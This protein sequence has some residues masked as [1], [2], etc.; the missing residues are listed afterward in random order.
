LAAGE[1]RP[2]NAKNLVD[3]GERSFHARLEVAVVGTTRK[4]KKRKEKKRVG[5][6]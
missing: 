2:V 3:E 4:A 6:R 5:L 1:I